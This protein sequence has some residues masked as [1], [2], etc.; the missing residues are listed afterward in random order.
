MSLYLNVHCNESSRNQKCEEW[1]SPFSLPLSMF[2]HCH[3]SSRSFQLSSWQFFFSL[4][5]SHLISKL[6]YIQRGTNFG[7]RMLRQMSIDTKNIT[8]H[9]AMGSLFLLKYGLRDGPRVGITQLIAHHLSCHDGI[10]STSNLMWVSHNPALVNL[11]HFVNQEWGS[12]TPP[13]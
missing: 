8:C 7:Y 9:S 4:S 2:N 11:P 13:D 5:S 10:Y 1:I 6:H 3:S 12:R